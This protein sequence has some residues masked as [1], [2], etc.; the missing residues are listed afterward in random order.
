MLLRSYPDGVL[1]LRNLFTVLVLAAVVLWGG[2]SFASARTGKK[3]GHSTQTSH[4]HGKKHPAKV[5]KAGAWKKQGQHSIDSERTREIQE[6]LIREHYY[7]GTADGTWNSD[8]REA[9]ESYQRDHGWQSKRVPDSRA[10]IKLGLG[11]NHEA[12]PAT[13]LAGS[14]TSL[15]PASAGAPQ[16]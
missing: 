5:K 8:T 1:I 12:M 13:E 7:S 9:M 11:P 14:G 16:R 2:S 10:L 4:T 3:H 15:P 6:A